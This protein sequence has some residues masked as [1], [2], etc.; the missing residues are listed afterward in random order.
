MNHRLP[1]F[2]VY[3]IRYDTHDACM[4]QILMCWITRNALAALYS[5]CSNGKLQIICLC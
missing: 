4:I 1:L 2:V 3:M 5:P